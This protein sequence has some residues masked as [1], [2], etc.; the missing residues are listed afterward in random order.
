MLKGTGQIA[1]ADAAGA[2][3]NEQLLAVGDGDF[4]IVAAQV[5]DGVQPH[6]FLH[7]FRRALLQV[8][9]QQV[10]ECIHLQGGAPPVFGG[11]SIQREPLH[12]MLAA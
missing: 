9:V 1:A 3:A 6:I 5:A 8:L 4:H 10:H 11:E 2:H 7:H 12:P